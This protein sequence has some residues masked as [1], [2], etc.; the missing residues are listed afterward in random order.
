MALRLKGEKPA[1]GE[2][3]R[4][5]YLI[6]VQVECRR[7]RLSS[8]TRDR[9][10][11]ERR[12]QMVLDAMRADPEVP[13]VSLLALVRGQA[14]AH[15]LAARSA[16]GYTLGEATDAVLTDPT[17]W[18]LKKYKRDCEK[19]M[20]TINAAIPRDTPVVAINEEMI[21]KMLTFFS[22]RGNKGST[23]NR[24]LVAMNIV[25]TFCW[26]TKRIPALP[27]IKKIKG[28]E[29]SRKFSLSREEEGKILSCL[30]KWDAMP[31]TSKDGGFPRKF[32]AHL[33]RNFYVF[34]VETGVR[35]SEGLR[36]RWREVDI[37][38]RRMIVVSD[39]QQTTKNKKSRT[40]RLTQRAVDHLEMMRGHSPYGPFWNLK[41]RRAEHLWNWAKAEAGFKD[42]PEC[43]VHCLRHTFAS[44]FLE[45]SHGNL[46]AAQVL[47]GH[48]SI[49]VTA[50]TYS[51]LANESLDGYFD[52]LEASADQVTRIP[53][54]RDRDNPETGKHPATTAGYP[55][56]NKRLQ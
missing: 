46:K 56:E 5:Y 31:R 26:E 21:G 42:E 44:R 11:A 22:E 25:L 38:R 48:S 17:R 50:D 28:V 30:M 55:K 51:H 39:T 15:K 6:D 35:L 14:T 41:H 36:V 12:E 24:K 32:D 29:H 34:L 23:L 19:I 33:Y 40:I 20:K 45:A 53:E 27:R 3:D 47:L 7:E 49:K 16:T 2:S 10:L 9:A 37:E 54:F 8:G 1:P 4:R 43:V 13:K 52:T 18:G